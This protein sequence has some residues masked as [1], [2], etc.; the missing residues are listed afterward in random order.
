MVQLPADVLTGRVTGTA[1]LGALAVQAGWLLAVG[2][3]ARVVLAAGRR[4]LVVQ[5][6]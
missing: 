5:G 2:V 4:R 6:G 1:A 3:L